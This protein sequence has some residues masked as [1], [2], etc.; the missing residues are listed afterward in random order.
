MILLTFTIGK[1]NLA[2]NIENVE[3]VTEEIKI[4]PVPKSPEFVIGIANVRNQII[5][6][7][8]LARLLDSELVRGQ[9]WI[10]TVCDQGR[11]LCEIDDLGE[12]IETDEITQ[13]K[14]KKGIIIGTI[15]WRGKVFAIID[16]RRITRR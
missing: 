15:E 12:L 2:F 13:V 8:S 9:K 1:Q 10:I 14:D 7:I 16:P 11:H 4:V 3:G 5:P 6:V